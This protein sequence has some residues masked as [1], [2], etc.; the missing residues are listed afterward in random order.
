M[1]KTDMGLISRLYKKFLQTRKKRA[2]LREK[3][4]EDMNMQFIEEV[5]LK[6]KK[7]MTKYSKSLKNIMINYIL[8]ISLKE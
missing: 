1:L 4:T 6:A 3:W 2:T 8:S 5:T 7:H